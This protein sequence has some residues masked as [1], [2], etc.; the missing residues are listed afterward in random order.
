MP[1]PR[2]ILFFGVFECFFL[3]YLGISLTGIGVSKRK[4]LMGGTIYA[5]V[6]AIT[7]WITGMLGI[8]FYV[9]SVLNMLVLAI[10]L[11]WLTEE[12]LLVSMGAA[13]CSYIL[14]FIGEIF[15]LLPLR[16]YIYSEHNAY[17]QIILGYLGLIPAVLT[18]VLIKRFNVNIFSVGKRGIPAGTQPDESENDNDKISA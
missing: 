16:G 4:I 2:V 12:K 8:P 15:V 5:I 3:V 14:C 9:H 18:L 10:I 6:P 11:Y 7:R 1:D 17:S 13:L